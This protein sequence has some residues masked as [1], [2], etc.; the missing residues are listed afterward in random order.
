MRNGRCW[1]AQ[2]PG[3]G[4]VGCGVSLP[5]VGVLWSSPFRVFTNPPMR[6]IPVDAVPPSSFLSS[7]LSPFPD[8]SSGFPSGLSPDVSPVLSPGAGAAGGGVPG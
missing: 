8:L 5:G 3:G 6:S 2:P 7:S 1:S 4:S